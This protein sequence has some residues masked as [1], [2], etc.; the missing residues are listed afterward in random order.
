MR[1]CM[2][3]CRGGSVRVPRKNLQMIAG[4]PLLQYALDAARRSGCFDHLVLAADDDEILEAG[5]AVEGVEVFKVPQIGPDQSPIGTLQRTVAAYSA[6]PVSHVTYIRATSPLVAPEDL[7]RGV[8][9]YE[10]SLPEGVHSLVGVS[11]IAGMHPSR[12]KD[13]GEDGLLCPQFPEYSEGGTPVRSE[14]L[15]SYVRNSAL[16]VVSPETLA[17]GQLYGDRVVPLVMPEERSLD[18]N[19]AFDLQLV[20]WCI[21]HSHK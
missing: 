15:Q 6:Q 20:K 10:D 17:R 16:A 9:L 18:V 12:L 11:R 4:R 21:E 2:M 14:T 1:L 13:I 8:Q 19:S 3:P 5:K 7:V